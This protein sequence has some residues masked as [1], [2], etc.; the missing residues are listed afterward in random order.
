MQGYPSRV[1]TVSSQQFERAVRELRE[2][3]LVCTSRESYQYDAYLSTA[4]G[5]YV[6][7]LMLSRSIPKL[8]HPSGEPTRLGGTVSFL[9]QY[10]MFSKKGTMN[11]AHAFLAFT[12]AREALEINTLLRFIPLIDAKKAYVLLM[13]LRQYKYKDSPSISARLEAKIAELSN[14]LVQQ[15]S[16]VHRAGTPLHEPYVVNAVLQGSS[17]HADTICQKLSEEFVHPAAQ[18]RVLQQT[19]REGLLLRDEQEEEQPHLSERRMT[20]AIQQLLCID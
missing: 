12:D 17:D 1:W 20:K 15:M 10:S 3:N 16:R 18:C 14:P 5:R 11:E 2:S 9:I 4:S 19:I 7:H 6:T 8:S 13:E